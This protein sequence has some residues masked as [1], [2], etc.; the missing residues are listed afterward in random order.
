M[1]TGRDGHV[2]ADNTLVAGPTIKAIVAKNI[3]ARR[4]FIPL[5]SGRHFNRWSAENQS[6]W[7]QSKKREP[8]T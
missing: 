8:R 4:K 3:D 7:P 5:Y 2:S 1:V 6:C